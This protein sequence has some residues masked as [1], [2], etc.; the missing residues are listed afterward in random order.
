L[1]EARRSGQRTA[2]GRDKVEETHEDNVVLPVELADLE[3]GWTENEL[4]EVEERL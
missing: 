1:K 3:I 4:L 2:R